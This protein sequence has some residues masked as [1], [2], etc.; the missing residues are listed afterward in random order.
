MMMSDSDNHLPFPTDTCKD[1][2]SFESRWFL[3][4]CCEPNEEQ[5][6]SNI[7]CNQPYKMSIN[8][9]WQKNDG[10]E[11]DGHNFDD[12]DVDKDDDVNLRPSCLFFSC[13]RYLYSLTLARQA[14]V[15]KR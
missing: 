12:G 3:D 6:I 5:N 1:S 15:R 7:T 11:N 13:R 8:K 10:K 9:G 14:E 2:S 4:L